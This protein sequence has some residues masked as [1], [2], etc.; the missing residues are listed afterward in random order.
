MCTILLSIK[1]KYVEKI[2]SGDKKFEFRRST[3]NRKVDKVII[4]SS[5]PVMKI[6]GEFTVRNTITL[7]KWTM[8]KK[9]MGYQG[10]AFKDFLNYFEGTSEAN[11]FEIKNFILYKKSK[12]L[13]DLGINFAPQSFVYI[14]NN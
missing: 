1:P 4:Y 14:E 5:H 12:K 6:I 3:P 2:I 9:T 13:S 11:A 10:L 7:N 8:W